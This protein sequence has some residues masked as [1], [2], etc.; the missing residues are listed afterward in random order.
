M[1]Y[2][3]IVV[4]AGSAG[5]AAASRLSEDNSRSVLLIE[6][7]PDY[8]DFKT[9][10]DDLK[11]GYST[12]TDIMVSDN[13]MR[14]FVGRTNFKAGDLLVHRGEVTGGTSAINGQAFFRGQ[15]HDFDDWVV[16]GNEA[17]KFED[18]LPFF[19]KMET[20]LDFQDDF[21]GSDGPIIYHRYKR[22]DWAPCQ[23]AFYNACRAAGFPAVD[24]FNRPDAHGVGTVPC[25][26]PDGIRFSTALG[27][28]AESRR[29]LNLTLRPN[30]N[31]HR[32]L[33][34]GKKA[35]GVEVESGG[36]K[37]VVES[38]EIILSTGAI[39]SPQLLLLSGVGP[40]DHMNSLGIPIVHELH[41]VGKNLSDHPFI[42]LTASVKDEVKLVEL[43]PRLQVALRY[44]A[45]GSQYTNDMMMLMH[46]F[47]TDRYN[48]L[49]NN[50]RESHLANACIQI[51]V[52]LYLAESRGEV[53][54]TST[55]PSVQPFLDFRLLESVEDRRRMRE[56]I[57]IATDLLKHSDFASIVDE[58]VGI[59][60]SDLESDDSLDEWIL[61]EVTTGQHLT[62]TCKM[63]PD[64]DGSAV[65]DQFLKVHGID[66][67][68]VAD[69]SIMPN[70]VRANTNAS[71]IM[72]G[73]RVADFIKTGR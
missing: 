7:G 51:N 33:F 59:R 72:I 35:V 18:V 40:V 66:G 44:T 2:D 28:L 56:A 19:R 3:V 12:G 16:M 49:R 32:I 17:W 73:E 64:S 58:C 48:S 9:L 47:S 36:E 41:G 22:E 15:T 68:R 57:R 6:A 69:A 65:V 14:E 62:G 29:R 70:T 55:D 42:F 20:D 31:V 45:S 67:L 4:G 1:K 5:A 52:A 8:P 26:N 25:N 13:H 53:T 54:L 39:G 34:D 63:G 23:E 11:L 43:A 46:S 27:Y 24:D 10:P 30:C 21:H 61:R 38:N 71:A 50:H 37:F 60:N